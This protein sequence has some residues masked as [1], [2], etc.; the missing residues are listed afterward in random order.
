MVTHS[1]TAGA[2]SVDETQVKLYHSPMR[3]DFIVSPTS[4]NL[5]CQLSRYEMAS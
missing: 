5:Q 3:I 1:L 2:L 4:G